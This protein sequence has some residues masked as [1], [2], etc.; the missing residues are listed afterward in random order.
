MA[1]MIKEVIC[2]ATKK[3][4][5]IHQLLE[6]FEFWKV[7]RITSGIYRFFEN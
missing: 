5:E 7:I 2:I 3:S 1:K 6:K 4:E